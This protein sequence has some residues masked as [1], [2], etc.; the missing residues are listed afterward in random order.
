MSKSTF[1]SFDDDPLPI[2]DVQPA[3]PIRSAPKHTQPAP[4]RKQKK[5]DLI[6]FLPWTFILLANTPVFIVVAAAKFPFAFRQEAFLVF[7][8]IGF[9]LA[10][11]WLGSALI[12][13]L[14]RSLFDRLQL[15]ALPWR[16]CKSSQSFKWAYS[17]DANLRC[18]TPCRRCQ[19][20]R[21][22]S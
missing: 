11:A 14:H 8:G 22:P 13:F 17:T 3:R 9:G 19:S 4:L 12:M 21:I 20:K 6:G 2:D 16:H 15:G 5:P 18:S 7:S 10:L 1:H